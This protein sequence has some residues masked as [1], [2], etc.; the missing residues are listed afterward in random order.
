MDVTR[1]DFLKLSGAAAS[2]LVLSQ[3]L[4]R[5]ARTSAL[6][7]SSIPLHKRIGE[8]TT[9]CPYCGV[10][11]SMIMAVEDGK[12]VSLEGDPDSPINEGSLC[13]KG[14]SAS[15]GANSELRLTRAK[16][17]APGA[18]AWEDVSWDNALEGIA[19]RIKETRDARWAATDEDG[20]VVNRTL[21]IASLGSVFPTSEE[22]YLFSKMMRALGAVYME[23]EA[24]I[25]VSGAV[26]ADI[27]TVGRGPMSNHWRDLANSD[28]ILMIGGNPAESF[29]VAWKWVTQAKEKGAT[30]IHVDPRF[31]RTSAKS[32][33]YATVRPGTDLAFVG[34]MIRYA[35]DDMEVNP[36]HYNMEYVREYTNASFL[37]DPAFAGPADT[38]N[39]LFSGWDGAKYDK[40]TWQYQWDS[41]GT[42]KM[43]RTLQDPNCVF[44]LL[45]KHFARYTD[46]KVAEITGTTRESFRQIC[47]AYASTG[48]RGA[49]G[50]VFFSSAA[51]QRSTGTQTVR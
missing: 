14:A 49:A 46:D 50:V 48:K 32:D 30:L 18:Q 38:L 43:D 51:C 31:T 41:S 22:A 8:T 33:L 40:S 12:I 1:R 21:S 9:V 6:A 27:E 7:Q 5:S 20:R 26:A 25:C 11:C 10:G 42:P 39:G 23:N 37:I 44:Q 4:G 3:V 29:P 34:G 35:L 19:T 28:C 15:Q 17:R 36:E 2:G 13:P 45:K 24:R 16:H 47:Q